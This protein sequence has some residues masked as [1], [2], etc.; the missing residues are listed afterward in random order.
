LHC[1]TYKLYSDPTST[2]VPL[3]RP[4]V[5][6]FKNVTPEFLAH[7]PDPIV[8]LI[9]ILQ[10]DEDFSIL[11]DMSNNDQCCI[12]HGDLKFDNILKSKDVS[13]SKKV[14]FIDWELTGYGDPAYD[15]AT[16]IAN[17]ILIWL[18][19]IPLDNKKDFKYLVNHSRI[20]FSKLRYFISLFW[21]TYLEHTLPIL[22][23]DHPNKIK[24]VKYTGSILVQ[25]AYVEA[26]FLNGLSPRAILFLL[27]AKNLL[28]DPI[29][30]ANTLFIS[31]I[32]DV[33]NH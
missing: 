1:Q 15:I 32:D 20:P 18:D 29:S 4:F 8:E 19:S 28:G 11:L 25:Y 22:G 31:V 6:D 7:S 16:I 17:F 27:M 13:A 9:T 30:A 26:Y 23:S 21:T 5:P 12:V 33:I 24:C 14:V 3:H 10:N 2:G